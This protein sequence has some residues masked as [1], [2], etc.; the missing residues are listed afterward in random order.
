MYTAQQV[1]GEEEGREKGESDQP[2][3]GSERG[4]SR[5]TPVPSLWVTLKHLR[6]TWGLKGEVGHLDFLKG[7]LQEGGLFLT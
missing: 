5:A 3:S 4:A 1:Q 2:L 7:V 6:G